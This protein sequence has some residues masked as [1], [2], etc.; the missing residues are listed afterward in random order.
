M[1]GQRARRCSSTTTSSPTPPGW[2]ISSSRRA[3]AKVSG[4]KIVLLRDWKTEA[5]RIKGA[6]AIA[7]DLAE[8]ALKVKA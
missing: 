8:Q 5:D 1:A 2:S 6:F 4:N 7:K 3:G